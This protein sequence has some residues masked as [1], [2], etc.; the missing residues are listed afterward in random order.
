ML[1][2]A[3]EADLAAE[4]RRHDPD[5][6]LCALFVS[7]EHRDA[8]MA[9]LL[10]N[11]ELARIPDVVIQPPAGLIRCQWWR[12]AIIEAAAGQP[13]AQPIIRALAVPLAE[14]RLDPA[15]LLAMIDAREH[16]LDHL[17]PED[18]AALECYAAATAGTLQACTARLLGAD[19]QEI[20]TVRTLGAAFGLIGIVRATASLARRGRSLLP[21]SLTSAVGV[22]PGAVLTPENRQAIGGALR[23]IT[24]RAMALLDRPQPSLRRQVIAAALPAVL[25]RDYARRIAEAGFDPLAAASLTRSPL[26]PIRLW[27]TYRRARR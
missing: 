14:C 26:I 24:E 17:A 27:W 1:T 12:D 13:R 19:A 4:A 18:P 11:H 7:A 16:D 3:P 21:A 23:S 15:E 10:L 5:R 20:E 2:I 22:E 9:L 25:A 8:C 6:W